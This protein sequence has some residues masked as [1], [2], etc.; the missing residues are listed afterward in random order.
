MGKAA[1]PTL[2]VGFI[3][4]FATNVQN[5]DSFTLLIADSVRS[6]SF[7]NV[8]SGQRLMTAGGRPVFPR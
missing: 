6:G 1:L 8:L 3:N 5:S 2:Q 4:G 7:T